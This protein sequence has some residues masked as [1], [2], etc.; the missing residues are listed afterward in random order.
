MK[1]KH[2]DNMADWRWEVGEEA[3]LKVQGGDLWT[4]RSVIHHI[5]IDYSQPS[6]SCGVEEASRGDTNGTI[7]GLKMRWHLEMGGKDT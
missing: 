7:F 4:I 3:L 5:F 2:I 1:Y 6:N